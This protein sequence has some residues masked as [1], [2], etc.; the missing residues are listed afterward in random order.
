MTSTLERRDRLIPWY[1]VIFF[2]VL[3]AVDGVMA[4]L[5]VRTQTGMVTE[6]PYEKGLA[7]NQ[8]VS[9]A[10]EQAARGWKGTLEFSGASPGKGTLHFSVEDASGK[11]LAI[12]AA[13]AAISRPTQAGMDFTIELKS[14]DNVISFPQSGQW[15]L[16]LFATVDGKPFQQAKRIIVP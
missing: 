9:A 2:V 13:S 3:I 7:Y 14:G 15:E 8:T 16:R 10:N 4:T 6:H 1:F 12:G 11:P 5:A